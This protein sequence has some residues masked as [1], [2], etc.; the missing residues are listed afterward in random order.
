[1]SVA[2]W[3]EYLAKHCKPSSGVYDVTSN[4]LIPVPQIGNLWLE[5]KHDK[6]SNGV[7]VEMGQYFTDTRCIPELIN[8]F[9]NAIM[10]LG[11]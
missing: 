7:L 9:V 10:L 6:M 3:D 2:S 5:R 4:I 11:I 8:H 1:M